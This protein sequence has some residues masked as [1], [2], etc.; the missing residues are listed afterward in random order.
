MK[1]TLF[2]DGCLFAF[3]VVSALA[4]TSTCEAQDEI[5][6]ARDIKPILA[7][8]CFACHGKDAETRAADLRL[9]ERE[10]AIDAGAIEVGDA[11]SSSLIER[12]H[13]DDADSIMPPPESGKKLTDKEKA[14][15]ER[16]INDG[17]QYTEHWS[18]VAPKK[19]E[20]PRVENEAWVR[21]E[22]DRF[23]LSRLETEGLQP[24][25]DADARSLFRRLSLDV[26]GLPP[27]IEDILSFEKDMN[28]RGDEAVSDWIDKLMQRPAWGEHRAR[29]WLDAA[30]Y[31]DTHGMHFDNYRE[32]WPY[33]D[34]VIKAF[35]ND[36]R[37]D[38]FTIEQLAG[39]LLENPTTEQLVA[40]GFQRCNMTTN[41]GGT[42]EDENRAVY[43]A[44]RV[45]TFGWVYLGLTT[46]CCQCHD[47]K[48]DPISMKD[49]YSLA[50]FF[51]NTT[52]PPKDGNVK[53]G[54]GPV[55]KVFSEAQQKRLDEIKTELVDS[56][57]KRDSYR[58][59]SSEKF[60][61]WLAALPAK[62]LA[63][64]TK[65]ESTPVP[66]L[67]MP[68]NEGSGNQVTAA[69]GIENPVES[70]KDLQWD[71]SGK[72]GPAIVLKKDKT[73][74]LGKFRDF[75]FEDSFSVGVWT[76]APKKFGGAAIVAKMDDGGSHR[77]WDLYHQSGRYVVHI[78]DSWPNNAM[79][80]RTKKRVF[81]KDK[82]QHVVATYDGSKKPEGIRIFVDGELQETE[83]ER[84]TLKENPKLNTKTPLKVGQRSRSSLYDGGSVQDLRIFDG[85]LTAEEVKAVMDSGAD[86]IESLIAMSADERNDQQ[87][88]ALQ[89]HFL[90]KVDSD[91]PSLAKAVTDLEN[92]EAKINKE[93]P[94]THIQKEKSDSMAM[95][96]ILMRGAYDKPGDDVEAAPPA[97]LHPFAE[98]A[99]KN[100]LGLAQWVIDPAN[101]L[102][103]RV[104]VNRFWQELFGH[105]IVATSEDFGVMGTPPSNQALLDWLAVDF[106]ESGWDVKRMYK[107]MLMSSTYRQSAKTTA[108]KLAKDEDNSL[109][110]RGPRF[111]MDAEMIRDYALVASGLFNDKMYGRGARPY[112]PGNLW[113]IVGMPGSDTRKYVQD[114]GDNVYRRSLYSFWKRMSP[115][116]NLEA[117]NAPNREVCTVR[118]ERTNT[119]L[120]AL[121][122]LNDPQF[123]E[124]ARVLAEKGIREG[125]D[126]WQVSLDFV[127]QRSVGRKFNDVETAIVKKDYNAYFDF[128]RENSDDA[129]KLLK[130]GQAEADKSLDAAQV[131]AWT[132]V[133]NQLL[134][135]DEVLNK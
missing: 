79:K 129:K 103:A 44:D 12:I 11:Q 122:T 60:D 31:A 114:K 20:L 43:A 59:S 38:Q 32:M 36:M 18:L 107:K 65:T 46:N 51:R 111:R 105:G 58:A 106:R 37:F 74:N 61:A 26:T 134:N 92:E 34:W 73:I 48:F 13:D 88:A 63:P 126:D 64:E 68:L 22:V 9:D 29:Y 94:I 98:D 131:A 133:C 30:R 124:A 89:N 6:F 128:Y 120:Q 2:R 81:R 10:A 69:I 102:T 104:T 72:F 52:E 15:L 108:D 112:Q 50:A 23:I 109:L 70:K 7:E 93:A 76:K 24:A 117:F 91:F 130:V 97:V 56:I 1:N 116:P 16:W 49:Y 33:R 100:R 125:G 8:N 135:L 132:M 62:D 28:T 55:L 17:A 47:H 3:A 54:K 85:A 80:I 101:P 57:K 110:S 39:D 121:V 82:W 27:S 42:I 119:P 78:I 99:P 77:G 127:V 53:D 75:E 90:N 5:D 45:Q 67:Q 14:L 25:P 84:N 96:K 35:N 113:E 115:P 95:T 123:F 118:R 21:N 87:N 4:L 83:T 41:E 66:V 40:T 86:Y 19:S 71:A